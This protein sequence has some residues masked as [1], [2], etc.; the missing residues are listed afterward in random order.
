MFKQTTTILAKTVKHTHTH[1]HTHSV[2]GTPMY[3][4]TSMCIHT[5]IRTH[6]HTHS[7]DGPPFLWL[8]IQTPQQQQHTLMN[9]HHIY[10]KI[11]YIYYVYTVWHSMKGLQHAA[12]L[13]VCSRGR[14]L[15]LHVL[16][17]FFD[18]EWSER[19]L[20]AIEFALWDSVTFT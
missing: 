11:I 8:D 9:T 4:Y 13:A 15:T 19:V 18:R 20:V 2:A 10:I 6:T 5:Y 12:D 14:T 7:C 1:T 16:V 17:S 3:M